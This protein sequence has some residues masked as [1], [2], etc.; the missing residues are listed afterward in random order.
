LAHAV[1]S[2]RQGANQGNATIGSSV[3]AGCQT[4]AV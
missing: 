3:T 2:R 4:L 1:G